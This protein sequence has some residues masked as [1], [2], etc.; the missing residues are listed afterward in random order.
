MGTIS[1]QWWG[2]SA[3]LLGAAEGV[4][5]LIDPYKEGIGYQVPDVDADVTTISHDHADHSNAD[6]G[7]PELVLRGLTE[8]GWAQVG[9]RSTVIVRIRSVPSWHDDFQGGRNS[10]FVFETAGLHIVHLGDLGHALTQAQMDAI[11]RVDVLLV[12]VG[13]FFTIDAAEATDVVQQL[14]PRVVIPMHYKTD[15]LRI[16]QLEPVDAFL[17]GKEVVDQGS[18]VELNVDDLPAP[19]SAVVWVMQPEGAEE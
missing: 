14:S 4:N 16:P 2:Q 18:T 19:G 1:L 13:G 11:G 6:A 10:I 3:F 15:S 5:I 9:D 7:S 17:E 12:P 8:D